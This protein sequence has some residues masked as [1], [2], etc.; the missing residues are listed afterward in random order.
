M[1]L[2]LEDIIYRYKFYEMPIDKEEK[3]KLLL[4]AGLFEEQIPNIIDS[5]FLIVENTFAF[6]YSSKKTQ[7]NYEVYIENGGIPVLWNDKHSIIFKRTF[8]T[9]SNKV[10]HAEFFKCFKDLHEQTKQKHN[11]LQILKYL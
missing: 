5:I 3:Q 7:I 1:K 8:E 10:K 4:E 11:R 6:G 2:L 9:A